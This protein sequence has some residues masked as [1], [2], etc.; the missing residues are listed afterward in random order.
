VPVGRRRLSE[1]AD[2]TDDNSLCRA[3]AAGNVEA[4]TILVRR[5]ERPVRNFL[6]RVAGDTADDIAQEAFLKA[7]R[8]AGLYRG[9]GS[10]RGWLMRIAWRCFLSDR[11]R[12]SAAGDPDRPVAQH[13]DPDLRL[14]L[15]RAFADLAPRERA[16]AILC[17][18]EGWSHGDA[19]AIL[20]LPLGTLKSVA[21][22]ARHQLALALGAEA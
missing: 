21:A 12:G 14:D 13:C 19:A 18:G 17:Y 1:R 11:R 9:E 8:M 10:Y 16:A 20:D 3:A 5:H 22:R 6:G 15:E 7:W 4:F 2:A